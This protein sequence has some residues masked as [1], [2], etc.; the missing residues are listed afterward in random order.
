MRAEYMALM[1][2]DLGETMAS[3]HLSWVGE[4]DRPLADHYTENALLLQ[5]AAPALRGREQIDLMAQDIVPATGYANA[6]MQDFIGT[7]GM[8]VL[9]GDYVLRPLRSGH[10]TSLGHHLTVLTQDGD[11][12]HIRAQMFFPDSLHMAYPGTAFIDPIAPLSLFPT[13]RSRRARNVGRSADLRIENYKQASSALLEFRRLWSE[14]NVLALGSIFEQDATLLL[15]GSDPVYGV[16]AVTGRLADALPTYGAIQ[17]VDLDFVRRER[18]AFLA[19]RY[20]LEMP[21][22]PPKTG[23]YAIVLNTDGDLWTIRTLILT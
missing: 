22:G 19:G 21:G 5:P 18:L 3:W 16:E 15:P 23:Y 6:S 7:Q 11:D 9:F 4:P 10:P 13:Q 1:L 8:G 20:F 14:G 17:T 2:T 12:W